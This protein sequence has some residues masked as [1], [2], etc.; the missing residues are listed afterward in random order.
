MAITIITI[1]GSRA[2]YIEEL[3][4]LWLSF[5]ISSYSIPTIPGHSPQKNPAP[6]FTP[7]GLKPF[8]EGPVR[9]EEQGFSPLHPISKTINRPHMP[10]LSVNPITLPAPINTRIPLQTKHPATMPA[11]QQTTM[12]NPIQI[13][14]KNPIHITRQ[15]ISCSAR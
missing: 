8:A 10:H 4:K 13:P 6:L 11:L 14:K 15:R 7:Q 2:K 9:K 12:P 1:G 3:S 5:F